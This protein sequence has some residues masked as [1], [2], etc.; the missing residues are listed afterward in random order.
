TAAAL[1]AH[2]V[3]HLTLFPLAE[4]EPVAWLLAGLVL[5]AT[6][7]RTGV[8]RETHDAG[9]YHRFRGVVRV[10]LVGVAVV[11]LVAGGRDVAA[12]RRAGVAARALAAGDA[13]G[14]ARAAGD[15]VALRPDVVRL[16]LLAAR[17]DVAAGRGTLAALDQVEAALRTSPGDPIARREQV[18]LL[19]ARA[20][21]TEVPAHARAARRVA[22]AAVAD[23][24][25]NAALLL[26]A[27][28]AARLD[29]DTA[30]ARRAWARAEALA[31]RSPAAPARL[32]RLHHVEGRDDE[33]RA[34]LARARAVDP[35]DPAVVEVGALI[36]G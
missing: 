35:D 6:P 26:L 3:G 2:L 30:A 28:D 27:G 16:R 1:V 24:P 32:A 14:A 9:W 36:E 29:G 18:R 17:A 11:A 13:D 8:T 31:P 22:D 4:V 5:T 21:A 7:S 34:A 19:V 20:E 10:G 23:D 25:V 15:A 12:D 33:A